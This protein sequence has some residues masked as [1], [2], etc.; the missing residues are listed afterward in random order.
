MALYLLVNEIEDLRKEDTNALVNAKIVVSLSG[1]NQ[2][3][4]YSAPEP[5]L[6]P[7]FVQNF[8]FNL[9]DPEGR[10]I[11]ILLKDGEEDFAKVDIPL[12]HDKL[13]TILPK[14]YDMQVINP[15]NPCHP[16]LKASLKFEEHPISESERQV[17]EQTET[18]SDTDSPDTTDE[19]TSTVE[20]SDSD[21]DKNESA[22][23]DTKE[24]SENSNQDDSGSNEE[25]AH[26]SENTDEENE[27]LKQE[28]DSPISGL[29]TGTETEKDGAKEEEEE[30]EEEK[31]ELDEQNSDSSKRQEEEDEENNDID[32]HSSDS[33][34]TNS[35]KD[36]S[37]PSSPKSKTLKKESL[38]QE[39]SLKKNDRSKRLFEK[40]KSENPDLQDDFESIEAIAEERAQ[41][42]YN[43][44][45]KK[46][47][48]AFAENEE[49]II[50]TKTPN[51]LNEEE[52]EEE[53]E[54]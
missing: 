27:D 24:D 39:M 12:T 31:N 29:Q 28:T 45:L 3:F 17:S 5:S 8:Q 34:N 51:A 4:E 21:I 43:A 22:E 7:K 37:S 10:T 41:E 53:S 36:P 18:Q 23:T 26:S 44:F 33:Q 20:K 42:T 9:P 48:K 50:K 52:E 30:E 1:T 54:K 16:K 11:T 19:Q 38:S 6:A 49:S 25:D 35:N 47:A 32:H 2:S 15:R 13:E 14:M 40:F 46:Y